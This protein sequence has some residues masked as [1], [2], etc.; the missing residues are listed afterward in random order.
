MDR[1]RLRDQ[2][3]GVP[4]AADTR[5]LLALASEHHRAERLAEAEQIYRSVIK[6]NPAE[7]E[8]Q[9][10]LGVLCAQSGR[11]QAA[12]E[13]IGAAVR[14]APGEARYAHDLGYALLAAKRQTEAVAAY[15]RAIG[16]RPDFAEAHFN[17]GNLLALMGEREEAIAC[18]RRAIAAAPR[19]PQ[20]HINLG[21]IL[22]SLRRYDEAV[23]CLRNAVA[24][25]PRSFGAHYNLGVTLA[26][27]RR[28]DQAIAAYRKAI[29]IDPQAVSAYINLSDLLKHQGKL[30]EAIVCCERAA[31]LAPGSAPAHVNLGAALHERGELRR[32]ADAVRRAVAIQPGDAM[33]QANLGQ[34]LRELGD[35][36]GAEAALRRA[37]A[38]DPAHV[39]AKAHL[40]IALQQLGR[41]DEADG[42]LDY[43][44]L[45]AV[46]RF[47]RVEGWPSAAMFN[48]ELA[49]YVYAHPT[50]M[51]DP[52]GKAIRQGSQTLE[53]LNC[54]DRPIVALQR[55]FEASV[56]D[57]MTTALHA[58]NSSMA[59]PHTARFRLEGWAVVLRTSGYQLSHF[60][61]DGVVSGVYY[62]QVPEV[63][64]AG[65][66]GDAGCIKFGEPLIGMAG[67]ELKEAL[68]T[69]MV[70]PQEG[71]L[72]LFPSCYWHRVLPF[73]SEQD[74]ICIAFNV[75]AAPDG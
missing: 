51:R 71:M 20:A 19:A 57:Y 1:K 33:T 40:P 68:L 16:L 25:D 3:P 41:K 13:H 67:S 11:T 18:Y 7:A 24:V 72:V 46:R 58:T 62:V 65:G 23:D 52:P 75:I 30:D 21:I 35:F 10:R 50:L 42:L 37:I 29:A 38:I 54:A 49:S 32:A 17:L 61:H 8:A 48:A 70:T 47:E 59:P 45:L 28:D 53:I 2:P 36:A 4:S 9:R 56:A 69:R 12:I 66:A 31:A 73:E 44:H 27:Q 15:R 5:G 26:A 63:I 64:K 55:F 14:L 43:D 39:F 60:H 22:Q 34:I 74:R 6:A